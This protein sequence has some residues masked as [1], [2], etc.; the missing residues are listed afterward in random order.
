MDLL[1]LDYDI[2]DPVLIDIIQ[3]LGKRNILRYGPLLS[4]SE[5]Q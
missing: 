3:E 1:P 2:P 4:G 5:K